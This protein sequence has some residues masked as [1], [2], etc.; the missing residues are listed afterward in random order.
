MLS[1]KPIAE[2]VKDAK[3]LLA[4]YKKEI[5]TKKVTWAVAENFRYLNSFD[6]AA[7]AREK[8][9]RVLGFRVR[10]QTM[11]EGGKYFETE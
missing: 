10:M 4:W 6:A 7:E 2:N 8:M 9:G 1:E 5:D 11:V 3:D